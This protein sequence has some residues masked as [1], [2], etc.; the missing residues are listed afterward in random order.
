MKFKE[1]PRIARI[2]TS[3][4]ELME[5][6]ERKHGSRISEWENTAPH[7]SAGK[8]IRNVGANIWCW[9]SFLLIQIRLGCRY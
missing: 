6:L 5:A 1:C 2:R 9:M 7:E 3:W 4:G 8:S